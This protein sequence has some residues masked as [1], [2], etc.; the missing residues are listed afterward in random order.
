MT[1]FGR[2]K[3]TIPTGCISIDFPQNFVLILVSEEKNPYLT[4][5]VVKPA[6]VITSIKQSSVLKGHIFLVQS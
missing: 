6:H 4:I 5:I 3:F 2:T 1:Y